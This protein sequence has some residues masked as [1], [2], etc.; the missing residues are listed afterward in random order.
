MTESDKKKIQ[1]LEVRVKELEGQLYEMEST[2]TTANGTKYANRDHPR[3][4]NK[5]GNPYLPLDADGNLQH[6]FVG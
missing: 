3:F 4:K 1:R 6:G 5:K 2:Y